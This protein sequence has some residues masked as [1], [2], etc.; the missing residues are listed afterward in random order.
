MARDLS[1]ADFWTD[2]DL[3]RDLSTADFWVEEEGDIWQKGPPPDINRAFAVM[4]DDG[5]VYDFKGAKNDSH[6]SRNPYVRTI[7]ERLDAADKER[8]QD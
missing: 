6:W 4:W 2:K 7:K 3:S 1:A 8:P 5:V